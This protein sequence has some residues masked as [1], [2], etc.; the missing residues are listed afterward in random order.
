[1]RILRTWSGRKTFSYTGSVKDDTVIRYGDDNEATVTSEQYGRLLQHFAGKTV[2]LGTSHTAP[3]PGSV[4]EWLQ[5]NVTKTGIA[6]YVGP[7]LIEEGYA[8]HAG[9]AHIRFK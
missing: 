8:E 2:V 1:M 5:K 4:G 3:P 7:I 6:S 9:G